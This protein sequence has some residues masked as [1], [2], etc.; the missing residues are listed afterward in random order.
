MPALQKQTVVNFATGL[1][2]GTSKF[3]RPDGTFPRVSNLVYLT[4]GA[5][6]TCDGSLIQSSKNGAGPTNG[7]QPFL[8]IVRYSPTGGT[9]K[10]IALQKTATGIR[11][12]DITGASWSGAL[13]S[14][15]AAT[16]NP[17]A[18]QMG[19]NLALALGRTVVPELWNGSALA[20]ITNGWSGGTNL[21]AWVAST[22]Y[23]TGV[24]INGG[25]G[26]LYVAKQGGTS[27]SGSAPTFPTASQAIVTDNNIIWQEA[28]PTTP[29]VPKADFL[30]YHGGFLFAWGTNGNYTDN[31]NL[32]GPDGLWQSDL[33]N[34]NSWN[35]LN[36]IFVA[37]GDG[38]LPMGGAVFTLGEAGIPATAQLVLFKQTKT[39]SLLNFLPSATLN[40]A[41]SG[42]GCVAPR[43][44]QFFA[45]L[46]VM[47]LCYRGF[48]VF[49]GQNDQVEKFT[50]PI[51]SYLFGGL[52]GVQA[53]DWTNVQN[54]VAFQTDNPRMYVCFVPLVGSGG[55]CVRGFA[56]DIG[57]NA[58]TVI[59][60]PFQIAAAAYIPELSSPPLIGGANDGT[61]R[62]M[63]SG[64]ATWD[65]AQV[66]ASLRTPEFGNPVTP[67]F[68]R[69]AVLRAQALYSGGKPSVSLVVLNYM[70]RDGSVQQESEPVPPQVAG[71]IDIARKLLSANMDLQ[72]QGPVV[73]EGVEW[74]WSPEAPQP[75]EPN[76]NASGIGVV[77]VIYQSSGSQTVPAGANNVTVTLPG[78]GAPNA[79]Y[80]LSITPNWNTT[81]WI[82]Q[83]TSTTFTIY[84]NTPAPGDGSGS[85]DW[86]AEIT[87]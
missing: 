13:A 11:L 83:K 41:P 68:I 69:R 38:E 19:D 71:N 25:N 23:A 54:S 20:A 21:P 64:D 40:Q 6:R 34:P 76:P 2:A 57:E 49:D 56:Y 3:V 10:L 15:V 24:A 61:I 47:R 45:E 43:S 1:Y 53:I 82:S 85:I 29:P 26:H 32:T 4:R 8:F 31:V 37:K 84:F 79:S 81:F 62:R 58:W 50:D 70:D 59:D 17:T 77:T 27:G 42:V 7:E 33:N 67:L 75:I 60:L 52:P 5:L 86:G 63:F 22:I 46:G 36:A 14:A 30:F 16:S 74:H 73:L 51:R 35:P 66:V 80:I 78:I 55:S 44:V 39:F 12:V 72:F 48:A 18:V 65:G 87:Q 28:G 9:T